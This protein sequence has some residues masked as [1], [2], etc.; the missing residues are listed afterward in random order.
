MVDSVASF[1][2]TA[3]YNN[4][5]YTAFYSVTDKTDPIEI[6]CFST[7][8]E[9]IINGS[10][11][12]AIYALVLRNGEELDAI[13]T[14]SFGAAYPSSPT[15]GT[16]FYKLDS[17]KKSVSLMKYNGTSWV[18]AVASEQPKAVYSWYRRDA[19]GNELDKT[20]PCMM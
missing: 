13:K 3:T 19:S 20:K 4:K 17:T 14:T 10:G 11:V 7:L 2:C 5:S 6:R 18:E 9:Q 12:G 8:G 15:S 16:F 1:K